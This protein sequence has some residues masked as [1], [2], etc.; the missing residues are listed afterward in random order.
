MTSLYFSMINGMQFFL[1]LSQTAA[2][3]TL[4]DAGR[5]RPIQTGNESL[6]LLTKGRK[7]IQALWGRKVFFF[8]PHPPFSSWHRVFSHPIIKT[9][10]CVIW[11]YSTY[12]E[13]MHVGHFI[14]NIRT[15]NFW[16]GYTWLHYCRVLVTA[17]STSTLEVSFASLWLSSCLT[18]PITNSSHNSQQGYQVPPTQV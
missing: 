1:S 16:N 9:T 8:L 15:L 14:L 18:P 17:E 5:R 12:L 11:N 6:S 10:Q 4:S 3:E 7:L 2:A 13:T